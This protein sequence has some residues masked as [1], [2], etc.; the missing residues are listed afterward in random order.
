M[1]IDRLDQLPLPNLQWYAGFSGLGL[2]YAIVYALTT[3]EG[4]FTTLSSDAWCLAVSRAGISGGT[5]G[6][7]S[8]VMSR[9]PAGFSKLAGSRDEGS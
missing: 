9:E 8:L 5:K 4:L 7:S 6:E 1:A 3:P 2:F